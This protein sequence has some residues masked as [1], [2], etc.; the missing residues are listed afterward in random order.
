VIKKS[1]HLKLQKNQ[2]KSAKIAL[3]PGDP[4]RVV[5]IE[6]Q[7]TQHFGGYPPLWKRG[8]RGD[9]KGT[10]LRSNNR[11]SKMHRVFLKK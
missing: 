3:L 8:V 5:K 9:L 2:I 1:Y 4:F 10:M 7:I 6:K 11:Y